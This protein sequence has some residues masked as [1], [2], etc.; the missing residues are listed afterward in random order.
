MTNSEIRTSGDLDESMTD[1]ELMHVA[2]GSSG[3]R[4]VS[5]RG[6]VLC[7]ACL[8]GE[9]VRLTPDLAKRKVAIDRMRDNRQRKVEAAKK[10][11]AENGS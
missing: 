4:N 5:A 9:P 11:L 6:Y 3:C 7:E 10:L 2:C 8:Y 1:D